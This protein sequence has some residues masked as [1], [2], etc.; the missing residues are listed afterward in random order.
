M[1]TGD[2][3]R[4]RKTGILGTITEIVRCKIKVKFDAL[5]I[6]ITCYEHELELFPA[7]T[8]REP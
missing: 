1:K 8:E 6:P 7:V 2:T 3:V 4:I 5:P